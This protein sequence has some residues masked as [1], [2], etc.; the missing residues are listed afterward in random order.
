MKKIVFLIFIISC[1]LSCSNWQKNEHQTTSEEIIT[2]DSVARYFFNKYDDFVICINGKEV[3]S[4]NDG[5]FTKYM[6]EISPQIDEFIKSNIKPSSTIQSIEAYIGTDLTEWIVYERILSHANGNDK[7]RYIRYDNS[8]KTPKCQFCPEKDYP[9]IWKD[10]VS[11][12][13]NQPA[14]YPSALDNKLFNDCTYEIRLEHLDNGKDCISIGDKVFI[15]DNGTVT[16][17]IFK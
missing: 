8:S 14:L 3:D 5:I 6:S 2:E 12:I 9:D 11:T 15:W 17:E 10:I 13:N 4:L 16:M 7:V 1:C